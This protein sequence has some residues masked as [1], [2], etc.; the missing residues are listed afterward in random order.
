MHRTMNAR[1]FLALAALVMFILCFTP[2]PIR[3]MELIGR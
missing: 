2:A 3:P 1:L